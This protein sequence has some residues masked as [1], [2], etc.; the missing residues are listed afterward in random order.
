MGS[1]VDW[2]KL[3]EFSFCHKDEM[4]QK[5]A[6]NFNPE[7]FTVRPAS[8]SAVVADGS[9]GQN[10]VRAKTFTFQKDYVIVT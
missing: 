8:R 5:H 3:V 9:T 2:T 4:Q 7:G 10:Y 6:V 1:I